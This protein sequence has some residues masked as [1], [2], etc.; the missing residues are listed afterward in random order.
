M[1]PQC[2][3]KDISSVPIT[4]IKLDGWI[5]MRKY[6]G[7]YVQ[8]HKKGDKV[9]FFTSGGKQ[10]YIQYIA[11][12]ICRIF[13][14]CDVVLEAEYI[15]KSEGKLGDRIHAAK[16]TT[17]RKAF[18]KNIIT[19]AV[20]GTDTF[21]VFDI[22]ENGDNTMRC[23]EN[24]I[25][26][27]QEFNFSSYV[28]L[29]DFSFPS[30]LVEAKKI[31]KMHTSLGYEGCYAKHVSHVNIP[32]K[33]VNNAIKIKPRPTADLLCIGVTEGEGKH[34]G[35]IR[36][37]ILQDSM[38]RIVNVGSGLTDTER[39]LPAAYFISKI[40]EINYEQ[41]IDTYIQPTY[42]CIRADKEESD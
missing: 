3:G 35:K 42:A 8:I 18:E 33:R 1:I 34:K 22:L 21:K 16:L 30:T 12:D 24:R 41:I 2:K 27:L 36:A 6:D 11:R 32:G 28:Q 40:I 23:F 9:T 37:L 15:G 20:A 4:K 29:V 5:A 17:Y 14:G 31:A 38:K 10:F 13:A 7:N 39:S 19:K 26:L 25:K